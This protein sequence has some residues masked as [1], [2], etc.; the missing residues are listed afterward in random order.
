MVTRVFIAMSMDT[1]AMPLLMSSPF[2]MSMPITLNSAHCSLSSLSRIIQSSCELFSSSRLR[3][4]IAGSSN[5][6]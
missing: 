5:F 4:I 1:R 6:S 3:L 2:D